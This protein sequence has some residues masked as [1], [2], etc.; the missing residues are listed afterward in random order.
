MS[1]IGL[2]LRNIQL[3]NL[4]VKFKHELYETAMAIN[5]KIWFNYAT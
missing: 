1:E 4:L 2:Q 5:N 3:T